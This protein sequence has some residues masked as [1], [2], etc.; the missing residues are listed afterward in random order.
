MHSVTYSMAVSVDGY[1]V[2]PDGGFD[3][4]VPDDK[5]F[6]LS[7]EENREVGATSRS[8]ARLSPPRLR[9]RRWI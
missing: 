7:L 2:G 3:W 6:R 1:I 9:L 4:T 8:A 5:V